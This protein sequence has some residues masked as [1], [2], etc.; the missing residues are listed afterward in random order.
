MHRL[1][2]LAKH[3]NPGTPPAASTISL[4]ECSSTSFE[5]G[6]VVV[7]GGI[8]LDIQVRTDFLVL[9]LIGQDTSLA[10]IFYQ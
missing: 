7:V 2:T 5:G 3:L 4:Q 9:Q 6:N 10:C 8:V 1:I